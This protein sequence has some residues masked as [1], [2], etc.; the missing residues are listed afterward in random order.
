MR[1]E[2]LSAPT[3]KSLFVSQLQDKILSGEIPIG[4]ALPPERELAA[5]MQ[6]S[7]AVVNSGLAELAEEGFLEIQPRRG[8]FVSDYRRNGNISTLIALME[9]HGGRL[10]R[11][12][13]RS[14][15]EIRRALEHMAAEQAILCATE[16]ELKVLGRKLVELAMTE[17]PQAA[18]EAAFAFQHEL[19]FI[20]KNSILPIFYSSFKPVVITL[21]ERYCKLYGIERLSRNTEILYNYICDRDADGAFLWIDQY[22]EMAIGG[23]EQIYY[24]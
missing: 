6:V 3:L 20:S 9:Y 10:G 15:L 18:A 19:A 2:R 24:D 13:I 23:K 5:Q 14:I 17:T 22:L 8:T 12:E 21:W 7:R 4:T 1:F 16:E 11:Q